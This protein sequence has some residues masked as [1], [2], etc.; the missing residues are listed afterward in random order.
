LEKRFAENKELGSRHW[1]SKRSYKKPEEY[2]PNYS[3]TAQSP[4]TPALRQ[5]SRFPSRDINHSA[6]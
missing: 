5:L 1:L 4:S 3:K 2:G 6:K